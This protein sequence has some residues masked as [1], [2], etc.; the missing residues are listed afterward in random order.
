MVLIGS[1]EQRSAPVAAFG[2]LPLLT[3]GGW[4]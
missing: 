1:I 3:L 2:F 4:L